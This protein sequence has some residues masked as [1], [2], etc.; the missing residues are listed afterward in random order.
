MT[1]DPNADEPVFPFIG[2]F[3]LRNWEAP[4]PFQTPSGVITWELSGMLV[5]CQSAV[6]SLKAAT[7]GRKLE[8]TLR[9]DSKEFPFAAEVS[10]KNKDHVIGHLE[11]PKYGRTFGFNCQLRRNRLLATLFARDRDDKPV[12]MQEL[13]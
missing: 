9:I 2:L 10:S 6:L 8:G 5:S 4:H 7:Q 11:I 3:E 12:A 1:S 13:L